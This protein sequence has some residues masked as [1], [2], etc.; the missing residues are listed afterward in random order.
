MAPAI[1]FTTFES[2]GD[3]HGPNHIDSHTCM[4]KQLQGASAAMEVDVYVGL[5]AEI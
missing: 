1:F 5:G 2:T 3:S 4:Y